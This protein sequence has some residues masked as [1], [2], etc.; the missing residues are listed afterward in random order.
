LNLFTT[1][2]LILVILAF[3]IASPLAWY[4]A[5]TW[6]QR[7]AYRINLS[8]W[9]FAVGGACAV[10]CSLITVSAY[11]IKSAHAN[12]VNSLRSE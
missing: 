6:L 8:W 10:F 9:I 5:D 12:P 11:A 2:F 3:A 4:I 7:Y 1:E